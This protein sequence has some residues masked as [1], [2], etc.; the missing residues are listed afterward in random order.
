VQALAPSAE[1]TILIADDMA[2]WRVRVREILHGLPECQIVGEACDGLQAVQRVAE[3]K[4]DLVLLDIGMPVLDGLRAASQIQRVS[5]H[6]KI[7]FVTQEDD[8]DIQRA[9]IDTGALGYI[10]KSNA[11]SE[12]LPTI[13]D[14]LRNAHTVRQADALL[15]S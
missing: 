13:I 15:E 9:A 7:V 12:L 4:P 2:G 3:L 14:A 1:A 11:A 8:A 6:S 10:L 5:P